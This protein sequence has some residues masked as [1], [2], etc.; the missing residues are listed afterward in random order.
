MAYERDESVVGEEMNG[1]G[2]FVD[3]LNGDQF[4]SITVQDRFPPIS[5]QDRFDDLGEINDCLDQDK[6]NKNV[7][8]EKSANRSDDSASKSVY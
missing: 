5:A 8:Y 4:P 6:G 1:N 7:E 2:D 3:D